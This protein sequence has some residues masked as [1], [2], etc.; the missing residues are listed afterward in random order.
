[1]QQQG[2]S[3]KQK[4]FCTS[5]SLHLKLKSNALFFQEEKKLEP[6][7]LQHSPQISARY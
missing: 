6:R 1:M 7:A 3:G 4:A 5:V 2:S